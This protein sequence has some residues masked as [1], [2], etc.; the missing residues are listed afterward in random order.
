MV[1]GQT[2]LEERNASVSESLPRKTFHYD[3]YTKL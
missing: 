2:G 1:V 3:I